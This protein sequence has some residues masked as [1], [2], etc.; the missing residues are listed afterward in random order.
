MASVHRDVDMLNREK[1]TEERAI[2]RLRDP[3]GA[4][5]AIHERLHLVA[6]NEA[7]V[8]IKPAR[9]ASP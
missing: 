7:I 6:P 4:I 8:Y 5:P 9:P 2:R 1:L 3:R